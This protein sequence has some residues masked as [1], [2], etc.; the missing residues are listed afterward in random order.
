[1]DSCILIGSGELAVV[2]TRARDRSMALGRSNK[3]VYRKRSD[4]A[5]SKSGREDETNRQ[6]STSRSAPLPLT[7][8][9]ICGGRYQQA[10]A[11]Q[12]T[13]VSTSMRGASRNPAAQQKTRVEPL[14]TRE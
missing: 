14:E 9:G 7:R 11:R 2:R 13:C 4:A 1:M 8:G 3:A 6:E 12:S 10:E 5:E